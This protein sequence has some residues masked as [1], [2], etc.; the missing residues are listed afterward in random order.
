[1][2]SWD[3]QV[4]E[5]Y[6]LT[7]AGALQDLRQEIFT[8]ITK[9]ISILSEKQLSQIR[10][11]EIGFILQSTNL[12]PFLTIEQQFKLLSKYKKIH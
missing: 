5:K 9:N 4:Q 12:V 6:I 2:L 3:L 11:N 7:M 1:M 8:S 10:I